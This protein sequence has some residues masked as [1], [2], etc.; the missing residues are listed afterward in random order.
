[1]AHRVYFVIDGRINPNLADRH[2]ERTAQKSPNTW[3]HRPSLRSLKKPL[4][5]G[6]VHSWAD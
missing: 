6:A 1:M 2:A 3:P 4:P 5:T